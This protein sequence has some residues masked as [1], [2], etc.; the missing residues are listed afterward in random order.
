MNVDDMDNTQQ[1]ISLNPIPPKLA[2]LRKVPDRK[3]F[4]V[5]F[6]G[7][8]ENIEKAKEL[9]GGERAI[10]N[11]RETIS[12][13]NLLLKATRRYKV[14]CQ[15]GSKRSL[16]PYRA[17]TE[18]DI[19]YDEAEEPQLSF[20]VVGTIPKTARF[21]GLADFQHIMDPGDELVK[22][23]NDLMNMDYE[24]LISVKVD[25]TDPVEDL[26]TLQ[27]IPPPSVTKTVFPIPFKY[28]A[29]YRDETKPKKPGRKPKRKAGTQRPPGAHEATV[30]VG[31]DDSGNDDVYE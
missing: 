5:E 28:K 6:P 29:R 26:S 24:S 9:I 13:P 1:P 31:S 30:N 18:S 2:E 11:A 25:N 8:I 17:P 12:T 4:S 23:K 10:L 3:I 19:P 21:S 14:K 22:I 16:P 15:P 27:P 20:E 7:H